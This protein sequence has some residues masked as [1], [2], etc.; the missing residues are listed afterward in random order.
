MCSRVDDAATRGLR[1][2]QATA[3]HRIWEGQGTPWL[4]CAVCTCVPADRVQ[5][6][7][8][9]RARARPC[10]RHAK[11]P[12]VCADC[13]AGLRAHWCCR[14]RLVRAAAGRARANKPSATGNNTRRC[15]VVPHCPWGAHTA[16]ASLSCPPAGTATL[17]KGSWDTPT[18]HDFLLLP[19][20]R[21]DES[22]LGE[23]CDA[24]T[25]RPGCRRRGRGR[26][27]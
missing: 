23:A 3:G 26:A 15:C 4:V 21:R 10:Q 19:T 12:S 1:A 14:R 9:A 25:A 6:P 5:R 20:S 13:R 17:P 7:L 27:R 11:T 2:P 16:A 18:N 22:F 24:A 8:G